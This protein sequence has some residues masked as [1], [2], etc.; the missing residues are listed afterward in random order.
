[1]ASRLA[2]DS[3]P[4]LAHLLYMRTSKLLVLVVLFTTL[5]AGPSRADETNRLL[6]QPVRRERSLRNAGMATTVAGAA[7]F[8]VGMGLLFGNI[9]FDG[10]G[11][12]EKCGDFETAMIGAGLTGLGATA[13]LAGTPMWIVGQKRVNKAEQ[14]HLTVSAT[15]VRM[16]F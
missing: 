9:H 7:V 1:M 13:V 4:R 2:N 8:A 3:G 15:G 5:A 14:Q 12:R 10:C 11:Q 16:T 6:Q